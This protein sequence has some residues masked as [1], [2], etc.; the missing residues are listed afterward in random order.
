MSASEP[1]AAPPLEALD[2]TFLRRWRGA[3]AGN[4]AELREHVLA[5]RRDAMAS[6]HAYR[7]VAGAMFLSPRAPRHPRYADLLA[8]ASSGGVLADVGCAFGQET[9]ALIADG[10]PATQLVAADVT[11]AYWRLGERLFGD[12]AEGS[13]AHSTRA[14]RTSFADWAAPLPEESGAACPLVDAFAGAFAGVLSML[15]LHVLSQRQVERLLARLA[16]CAAPGAL[17]VGACV[18]VTAAPGEWSPTPDGSGARRW[19]HT[20]ASLPDA[21]RAAGWSVDASVQQMKHEERTGP[22]WSGAAT[23]MATAPDVPPQLG[24][25]C[26]LVFRAQTPAA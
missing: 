12:A 10:V 17:L 6:A 24:E 15:V 4:D 18:G 23:A 26:I 5:V 16:R 8:C 25:R 19:L 3:K 1:A 13:A 21:L 9:R 2:L 22:G 20:A 14:V 7:C 11:D